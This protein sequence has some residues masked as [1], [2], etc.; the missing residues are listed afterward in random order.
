[1]DWQS[2]FDAIDLCIES[3]DFEEAKVL[4]D[5]A[6]KDA[7]RLLINPELLVKQLTKQREDL[8]N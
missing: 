1:M 5:E 7:E 2:T 4:I 8:S 6:I 3:K